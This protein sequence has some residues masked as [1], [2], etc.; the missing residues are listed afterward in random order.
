MMASEHMFSVAHMVL[1]ELHA[2]SSLE[3]GE[4][5]RQQYTGTHMP[6]KASRTES[7]EIVLSTSVE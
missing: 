2:H 7:R 1:Y 6:E 4:K 3:H 5:N